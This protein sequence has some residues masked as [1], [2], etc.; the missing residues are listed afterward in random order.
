MRQKCNV[1]KQ[2]ACDVQE[3]CMFAFAM[4]DLFF[5][6]LFQQTRAVSFETVAEIAGWLTS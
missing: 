1:C 6:I 4:R 5:I 3:P 2:I